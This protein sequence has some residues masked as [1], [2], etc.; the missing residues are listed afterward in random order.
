[1]ADESVNEYD[2]SADIDNPDAVVGQAEN[3]IT[4]NPAFLIANAGNK[5]W[6]S[7]VEFH[8]K[9]TGIVGLL[10]DPFHYITPIPNFTDRPMIKV[11]SRRHMF[12]IS[13]LNEAELDALVIPNEKTFGWCLST[14]KL[15]FHDNLLLRVDDTSVNFDP[16]YIGA[17][18]V[19]DGVSLNQEAIGVA[20]PTK[21]TK[22]DDYYTIPYAEQTE[23]VRKSGVLR[24]PDGT[25]LVP[26]NATPVSPRPDQG[27]MLS[28]IHI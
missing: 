26:T 9:A 7:Y 27:L 10:S 19:Y 24:I 3:K 18:V 13:V 11:G 16:N 8:E 20:E 25:G 22:T 17:Q 14:G 5:I 28:L 6:Y 1:M 15:K 4:F 12:A 2:F 23:T 21:L